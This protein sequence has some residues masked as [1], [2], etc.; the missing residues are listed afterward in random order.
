[1]I[2]RG[3]VLL[4]GLLGAVGS[5]FGQTQS[6]VER[7]KYLVSTIMTC[8]NCHTPKGERGVPILERDLSNGLSWDEPPF[9]VTASNITQDKETG[10]GAWTDDQIKTALRKGDRPNGV[11]LAAVMPADFYEIITPGDLDAIVAYLRTVKPVKAETPAP[12]YR[13]ALPR[14]IVPGA[15]KPFS[16]ADMADKLKKGFYLATIGHCFECHTPMGPKGRD[17][18]TSYGK[19][20]FEFA[21][22]WGKSVS[23]N[24]TSSKTAGLGDWS[25]DE[26]KRAITKGL[27][28]DGSPLKPPMGFGFYANMTE[29]DLDALVTYLR[30][31]PAK[32]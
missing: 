11:H 1:M 17:F 24:I 9:K 12:V 14:K 27:R 25:D 4:A 23:R 20:G 15:E 31:V 3:I 13:I 7:G 29:P 8:Q 6:P 16:D 22:P 18:E 5:A 10:I 2:V 30:T 21:G 19:G 26:I 28:R 32:D